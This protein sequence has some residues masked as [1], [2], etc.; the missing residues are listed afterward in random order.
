VELLGAGGSPVS[1]EAWR[2][3]KKP[4]TEFLKAVGL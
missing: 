1:F 4:M 2:A 3:R